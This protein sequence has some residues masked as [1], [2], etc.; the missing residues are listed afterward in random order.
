MYFR[1]NQYKNRQNFHPH[2][3]H[4]SGI[5]EICFLQLLPFVSRYIVLITPGLFSEAFKF[6]QS[7]KYVCGL[8]PYLISELGNQL[9]HQ[10]TYNL[11]R[12]GENRQEYTIEHQ[13][14]F[15]R[16]SN[17]E[18]MCWPSLK[19][20][21]LSCLPRVFLKEVC[22]ISQAVVHISEKELNET[23]DRSGE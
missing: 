15:F 7:E 12:R 23:G 21:T 19:V 10:K 11:T 1:E 20:H 14:K 17:L 4:I 18:Q 6:I 13:M 9:C 22:K 5:Q 16:F 8:L 2:D 3:W